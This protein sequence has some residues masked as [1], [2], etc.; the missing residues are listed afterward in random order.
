ML[1]ED[2]AS[3]NTVHVW[4][5]ADLFEDDPGVCMQ[6]ILTPNYGVLFW[7]QLCRALVFPKK[8]SSLQYSMLFIFSLEKIGVYIA[9]S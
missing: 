1:Y 6:L 4:H 5:L 3:H 9:K 2:F 8:N 7:F